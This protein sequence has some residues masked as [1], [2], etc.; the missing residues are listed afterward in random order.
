MDAGVTSDD[1]AYVLYTS[2]STGRPKGVIVRHRNLV[3]YS[4]A[5]VEALAGIAGPGVKWATVSALTADLGHTCIFPALV[6]G[7]AVHMVPQ[8][9]ILDGA[10]LGEYMSAHAID[11]LK[12][13]PSHLSAV[14]TDTGAALPRRALVFGGEA[15][16]WSLVATVRARGACSVWNHYGPT[17]TTVGALIYPVPEAPLPTRTVPI[18]R[19]LGRSEIAVVDDRGAVVPVGVAGE[20]WIGGPGV[21]AGYV[22]QPERTAERFVEPA[23]AP[24]SPWYRTG[25]RVWMS[26]AGAV[27]FLGRVDDQVKI[28]GYR[29]EPG[30]V[31]HVLRAVPG[32]HEAAVVAVGEPGDMR[33]VGFVAA[34]SDVSD[35]VIRT[36][37]LARLPAYMVPAQLVPLRA[38]PRLGNGKIDRRALAA[39]DLTQPVVPDSAGPRNPVEATLHE[40]WLALLNRPALSIDDHFF[41]MGGHS[42]LATR[43]V[44]RVRKAFDVQLPVAGDF[45]ASDHSLAGG[46]RRSAP[47]GAV[48]LGR[49]TNYG[50]RGTDR[51]RNS[52][53]SRPSRYQVTSCA[54]SVERTRN[55]SRV[56]LHRSLVRHPDHPADYG[57]HRRRSRIRPVVPDQ[58]HP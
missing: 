3:A 56:C 40:I 58:R 51:E 12:I 49:R 9:A 34:G 47:A 42:L 33:L 7:G 44:A 6:S 45:R 26:A 23:W 15:L 1:P 50:R 43:L 35:D 2:G 18:G 38:L 8:A 10:L 52:G 4:A 11:V 55:G 46:A 37:L 29:V 21:A 30:E 25:D 39:V 22:A 19:P 28:R 36:A 57:Q 41:E 20:L 32:V 54:D 48:S 5:I 17:E 31:E 27:E 24:G 13:T 14:L 53:T 16:P